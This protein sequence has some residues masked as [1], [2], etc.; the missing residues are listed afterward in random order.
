MPDRG[1]VRPRMTTLPRLAPAQTSITS[2]LY[3]TISNDEPERKSHSS[4]GYRQFSNSWGGSATEHPDIKQA[5][6][7]ALGGRSYPRLDP[8]HPPK[9]GRTVSLETT[10]PH[11]KNELRTLNM[12]REQY[13]K[14]H[15]AW[16]KP[17]YGTKMEQEEY[18]QHIRSSLKDQMS[19]KESVRRK[20]LVDRVKESETAVAYDKQCL[21][22][23]KDAFV[24]KAI[25]LHKFRDENKKIMENKEQDERINRRNQHKMERELLCYNPINWSQSLR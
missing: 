1:I 17:V 13:H 3:P 16:M 7:T 11:Y 4:I 6:H 5:P 15:R 12:K 2:V 18:R 21:T 8:L 14:F 19:D 25:Y 22:A 23:D 20:F 9:V 24:K 10:N